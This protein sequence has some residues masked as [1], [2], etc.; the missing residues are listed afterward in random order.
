M[1]S[2]RNAKAQAE[3]AVRQKLIIGKPRHQ[4]ADQ[5]IH[6][7][8]T[9]RNDKQA[10]TRLTEWLQ[11]HKHGS[12]KHLSETTA[13]AYLDYRSEVVAQKTL[14]QD[15][16]AIQRHLGIK[17]TVI[18]SE[19]STALT[20]RA[21]T[22]A[23]VSLVA[24]SQ[25]HKYQLATHIAQAAGLRAHELLTLRKQT[26]RKASSHREWSPYRFL[27]REGERYTVIGK[28]GLIREVLIP[29]DLATQL[30]AHRLKQPIIVTDRNIHYRQYYALGGGKGWTSSF[31]AASKRSLGWS[32]GAH[33]LRHSYTQARMNELQQHGFIYKDAL[34]LVSQEL[35]HFRPDITEVYL[36]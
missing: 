7:L 31:S 34:A 11:Q 29:T 36:R 12:L 13:L 33:G 30:E 35:G 6:G 25:S 9:L 21:Y 18:K 1:P 23:Q 17:L 8:G 5:A 32:H 28:G 2:F 10:L 26:E 20:S 4:Q 16:Q 19:L 15:R 22:P 3:H 14:D 27:G 24:N